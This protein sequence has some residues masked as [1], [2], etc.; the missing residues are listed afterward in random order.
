[1]VRK[2]PLTS[3]SK[4]GRGDS[5][6]V[7]CFHSHIDHPFQCKLVS[8]LQP[9]FLQYFFNLRGIF[10]E[11]HKLLG[12]RVIL[13]TFHNS[14]NYLDGVIRGPVK[15]DVSAYLVFDI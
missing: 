9:G 10:Q 4:G 12:I 8:D 11:M 13:V 15:A 3:F 14:Q 7:P 5:C 2:S 6:K 1:M